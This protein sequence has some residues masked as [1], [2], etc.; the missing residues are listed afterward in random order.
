MINRNFIDTNRIHT[1]VLKKLDSENMSQVKLCQTIEIS[2]PTLWKFGK[3]ASVSLTAMKTLVNWLG[4]DLNDYLKEEYAD[5][6]R[7]TINRT[8]L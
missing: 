2:R 3:K 8:R 7:Q 5:I 4:K 1:D 6:N